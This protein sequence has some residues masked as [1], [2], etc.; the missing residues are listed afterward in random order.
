ML[1]PMTTPPGLDDLRRLAETAGFEWS[2]QEIQALLPAFVRSVALLRS[3]DAVD[4]GPIEPT[5]HYSV[6]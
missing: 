2:D 4:L 5:T 6:L 1:A 3:L